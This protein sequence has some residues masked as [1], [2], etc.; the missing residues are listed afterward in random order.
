MRSTR[1]FLT[2]AVLVAASTLAASATFGQ[3]T[4]LIVDG[5]GDGDRNN[6]GIADGPVTNASDVGAAWYLARADSNVSVGV[7]NDVGGINQGGA[8]DVLTMTDSTRAVAAKFDPT[9]LNDGDRIRAVITVRASEN[10]IDVTDGGAFPDANSDRRF[11]FGLYS[12]NGTP[13]PDADTNDNS[14][15]DDDT[16]FL[17][18]IDIGS[19]DGTSYAAF[20]DKA[21]GILGGSSVGLGAS[22]TNSNYFLENDEHTLE[23]IIARVGDDLNISIVFDGE[24]AQDGSADAVTIAAENLPYTYDYFAF[25]TS[26][27][28]V[29]YRL[30]N[31]LVEYVTPGD[32]VASFDGF[33]DGDYNNDGV[34]DGPVNDANDLGFQWFKAT[35]TSGVDVQVIDDSSGIGTANAMNVFPVTT[36]SRKFAAA[37]EEVTLAQPGDMISFAFDFRGIGFIP[38]GDRQFRFGIQNDG[39]TPVTTDGF[40]QSGDDPGYMAQLDTGA[41][42]NDSTA[43]VRGDL[44]NG[45]LGGSTRALGGTST[46]PLFR[47]DTNA[48]RRLELRVM[49]DFDADLGRDVNRVTLLVDGSV[50]TEGTDSGDGG[51]DTNPLEFTFNQIAFG[52]HSGLG[53]IDY[54]VDNVEVTT[55][56]GAGGCNPADLAEPFGSL[57]FGDIST[58]LVA[59]NSQDPL[60]DLALPTG[61]FT[62]GDISAFLTAFSS[63]C[64]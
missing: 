13:F 21:D 26:G 41:D 4:E 23:L 47:L 39:G 42:P 1:H 2:P 40:E 54:L 30:D 22:S 28:S 25:G 32:S 9:T 52:S 61:S 37:I 16:G 14:F 48:P 57:T 3:V 50:A 58:F 59:F 31:V 27:A 7:A 33:E 45:L 55:N 38:A 64:P 49:R 29:D 53:F 46:D 6:D 5:F 17:G 63:G 18:L 56:V 12:S 62:F 44:P 60:A 43:T 19:A 35:G 24:L 34:V 10:P 51:T 11:R 8:L 36:S 20:G 15:T